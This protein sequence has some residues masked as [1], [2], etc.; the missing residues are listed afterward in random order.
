VPEHILGD[1]E[2]CNAF[3]ESVAKV[4]EKVYEALDY[5]TYEGF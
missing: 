1:G 4:R 5:N 3:W 2:S